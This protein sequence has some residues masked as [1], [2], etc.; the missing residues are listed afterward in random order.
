M[1]LH[2]AR[3]WKPLSQKKVRCELCRFHCLISDGKRGICG[4]RENRSGCLYTLVYGKSIAE[5]IDPIEKKPLFHVCPGSRSL[6]IATVGCNFRCMHCQN[7]E[8]SQWTRNHQQIPGATMTPEAIVSRAEKTGCLSI[9]YTY[10]EPTIFMEYAYDIAVLAHT[11]GLKNIFVTNGYTTTQA[12]EAIAPYLDAANVDLKGFSDQ[13]Y[14][15]LTGAS[16][17]GVLECLKDYRR[18]GIWVE[19][20]TLLIPGHNDSDSELRQI[21]QFIYSELGHEVPWH[22][23][24]FYPS[25]KMLD[26]LPTPNSTLLR[27]QEVGREAGLDYV[28]LG[29]VSIP[30]GEDTFCPGCQRAI[31]KR[32]RLNTVDMKIVS[33]RCAYCQHKIPGIGMTVSK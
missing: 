17:Q 19:V 10:T 7:A 4:V 25:Y 23:S 16:L 33:G 1:S 31:V 11:A 2:K 30:G 5:N 8:I 22:V 12:L 26:R 32:V 28:Y 24:A 13:A 9:S 29:N 14:R 20:T 21:A 27:A 15:Q 18:L 3:F 6:S